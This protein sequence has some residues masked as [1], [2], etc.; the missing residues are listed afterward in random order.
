M[1]DSMFLLLHYEC[2]FRLCVFIED[3]VFY[4]RELF[5]EK[6]INNLL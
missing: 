6:R 3:T 4:R 5:E 1:T 2:G